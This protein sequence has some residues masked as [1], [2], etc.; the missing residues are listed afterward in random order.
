MSKIIPLDA[1]R[2]SRVK[3]LHTE[4]RPMYQLTPVQERE[5]PHCVM[6]ILKGHRG[7]THPITGAEMARLL[8]HRN[9][10]AIRIVIERLIADGVLIASSVHE[11]VGYF[12]VETLEE[13]DPYRATL[14]SRALKNLRRLANFNRGVALRFGNQYRLPLESV[15]ETIKE[16]G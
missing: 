10:R 12:L 3:A 7:A 9:D 4:T 5:L 13:V 1:D 15:E 6:E 16:L 2:P 14:R 11:P 8:H